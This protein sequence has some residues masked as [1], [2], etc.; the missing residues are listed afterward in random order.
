MLHRSLIFLFFLVTL[1]LTRGVPLKPYSVIMNMS[2]LLF[3]IFN[4]KYILNSIQKKI[5]V[6]SFL[7][8][9][10]VIILLGIFYSIYMGNEISLIIR[11]FMII[12]LVLLSYLVK[13]KKQYISLFIFLI[14]LQALFIILFEIYLVSSFDIKS[15]YPIRA[16]FQAKAWGDVYTLNGVIWKIQLLGNALL[17]F[18]LFVST[19]YYSGK[20]R[21]T[22]ILIFLIA[23][24]C[25]GNF[26]FILAISLFFTL[27]YFYSKRWTIQKIIINGISSFILIAIISIP[28]YTYLGDVIVTKAISSNPIRIDQAN[29]LIDDMSKDI[30]TIL[31]G[32]G[33]GNKI[34]IKTQW[35]DYSNSIYYELQSLYIMNQVGILFFIL[36]ILLNILLSI[37]FIKYK[38]LLIAY[39]SYI[40]YALFNPYFLDTNHIVVVIV[41]IS[42]KKV[43][44]ERK[45]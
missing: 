23:I 4:Y 17:P 28:L 41:L 1:F 44:D 32:Q 40:F 10:F 43:L 39:G 30:S 24:F 42:L 8:V 36:F 18:A 7:F 3:I 29:V 20:K 16:F 2:I 9:T 22:F 6:K 26:A 34:D 33:L 31:F 13:P 25:A 15:Y 5:I 38:L 35:R 27:Y 14:T 21:I 12:V 37:Y 11:F 45:E 19:I